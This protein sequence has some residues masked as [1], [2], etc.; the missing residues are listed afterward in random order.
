M[1]AVRF[2]NRIVELETSGYAEQA[3]PLSRHRARGT[4]P[5]VRGAYAAVGVLR[6]GIEASTL[7]W[8]LDVTL[9]RRA[10]LRGAGLSPSRPS[11]R[12][13]SRPGVHLPRGTSAITAPG[14][15]E[16]PTIPRPSRPPSM[17]RPGGVVHFPPGDYVSGTLRLRD[18]LVLQLAAGATLIASPDDDGFR[19]LREARVRD[20]RRPRDH[21]LQ[22]RPAPGAR[23]AAPRHRRAG[24]DRR[25]PARR[26]AARSRSRSSSA[27]TSR[28][29]T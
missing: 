21:R 25:Q 17:P 18:R 12:R 15:T 10:F 2:G 26:A 5:S 13:R 22:L 11:S 7:H 14:A 6:D 19:S 8:P 29:G 28:S 4:R 24:P 20:V 9:S 3:V 1:D 27:V 23:P 16:R